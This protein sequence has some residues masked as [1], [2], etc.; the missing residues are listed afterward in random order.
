MIE[1]ILLTAFFLM[2]LFSAH[3][4]YE[5]KSYKVCAFNTF[6][7]GFVFM[8]LVKIIIDNTI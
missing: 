6:C 1:A 8:H 5:I 4:M 7:A 3:K 2:N